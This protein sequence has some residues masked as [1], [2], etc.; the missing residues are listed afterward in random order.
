MP[1]WSFTTCSTGWNRMPNAEVRGAFTG[2]TIPVTPVTPPT[3]TVGTGGTGAA[4]EAG[5]A[6]DSEDSDDSAA[7]AERSPA[8]CRSSRLSAS[9]DC[10]GDEGGEHGAEEHSVL[11]CETGTAG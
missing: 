11:A 4:E 8:R 10:G 1:V 7:W 2:Q 3:T 6:E 5:G 9:R